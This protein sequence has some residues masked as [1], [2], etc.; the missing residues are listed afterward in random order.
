MS[1]LLGT[2]HVLHICSLIYNIKILLQLYGGIYATKLL[3]AF[4]KLFTCFL[5]KEGFTLGVRDIL[6]LRD[7]DKT[8]SKIIAES[9]TIGQSVITEA[10]DIPTETPPEEIED[11]IS[12]KMATN[13]KLRAIIDRQ[14]KSA[15][16]SYTNDINK[17]C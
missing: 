6:V 7:A 15:L 9:R 1:T 17:C 3:S 14:Y 13:P 5:Q 12:V 4:A 10:L 16:D 2:K 11:V 8:R